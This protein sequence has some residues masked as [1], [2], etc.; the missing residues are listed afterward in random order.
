MLSLFFVPAITNAAHI[1]VDGDEAHHAM[2]VLRIDIGDELILA[3]GQGSWA[4]GEVAALDKK[5]FAV[6][7][8]E[9]GVVQESTQELIVIQALMKSD[10]AK[11]AI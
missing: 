4:R 6:D 10:R 1:I 11:E 8:L 2:K 3:D 9:R 5:S 7:V